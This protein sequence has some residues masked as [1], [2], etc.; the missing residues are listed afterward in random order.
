MK[1]G[2]PRLESG[3]FGSPNTPGFHLR[4]WLPIV[5][6]LVPQ[7]SLAANQLHFI[8]MW[9]SAPS[10]DGRELPPCPGHYP[11]PWLGP[12][13]F[14]AR[15]TPVRPHCTVGRV[16]T[17]VMRPSD[18][19]HVPVPMVPHTNETDPAHKTGGVVSHRGRPHRKVPPPAS[20]EAPPC[21]QRYEVTIDGPTQ[22]AFA[23]PLVLLAS[24]TTHCSS[25]NRSCR[26]LPTLRQA[27]CQT[28]R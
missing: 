18:E 23:D 27:T 28:L 17:S 24:G 3:L 7:N 10:C 26:G 19:R 1:M 13:S 6:T 8:G 16:G 22:F 21:Q 25:Q 2:S 12:L 20:P 11:G 15:H 5:N 9:N 14:I 4:R